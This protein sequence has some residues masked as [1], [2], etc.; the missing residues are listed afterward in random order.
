M[1]RREQVIRNWSQ[2]D[3][4]SWSKA[5]KQIAVTLGTDRRL[6]AKTQQ[7]GG[8]NY[9]AF[10][11]VGGL[12]KRGGWV[13]DTIRA[14]DI[15]A[16]LRKQNYRCAYTG[17]ELTPSNTAADHYL[18]LD[19]GGTHSITNIR[20]VTKE[21]NRAKGTLSFDEFL[22]MCLSVIQTHEARLRLGHHDSLKEPN[23]FDGIAEEGDD[24][25]GA[26]RA[27]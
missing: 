13:K 6:R 17:A 2:R 25:H 22:A 16:L 12:K 10:C 4:D 24:A 5:A 18:P 1:T 7:R 11:I 20:L 23:L 8:W 27:A 9:K 19:R 3:C 14:R 15:M 21:V 26:A